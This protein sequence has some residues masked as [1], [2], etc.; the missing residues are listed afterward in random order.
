VILVCPCRVFGMLAEA[1][2]HQPCAMCVKR[3]LLAG[4]RQDRLAV[5]RQLRPW[6]S[7]WP[8]TTSDAP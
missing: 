1:A 4:P 2:R 5:L 7:V 3:Q 8:P 6:R